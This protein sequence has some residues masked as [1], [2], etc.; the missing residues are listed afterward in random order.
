MCF[1]ALA[2]PAILVGAVLGLYLVRFIPERPYRL[3]LMT[4]VAL[5]AIQLMI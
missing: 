5:A 3:F 4:T 1:D 2:V